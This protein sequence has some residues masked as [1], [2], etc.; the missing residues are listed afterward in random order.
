[1][2]AAAESSGQVVRRIAP[3]VVS[4]GQPLLPNRD[5]RYRLRHPNEPTRRGSL[6]GHASAVRHGSEWSR[7]VGHLIRLLT[8]GPR[9]LKASI[10]AGEDE[11]F[12]GPQRQPDAESEGSLRGDR[13]HWP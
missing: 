13:C 4:T 10:L 12:P 3:V 9:E 8:D 1:M 2:V 11:A 5:P 6:T 7:K